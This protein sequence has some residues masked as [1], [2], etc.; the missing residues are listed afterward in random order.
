LPS[1]GLPRRQ[2]FRRPAHPFPE[3]GIAETANGGGTIFLLAGPEIA[4]GKAAKYGG[5]PGVRAFALQREE[6][7]LH[8]IFAHA[9]PSPRTI[10]KL[11]HILPE[12]V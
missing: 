4:A 7:F 8:R 3:I 2:N 6:D 1:Q 10:D 11:K 12:G 5:A 9:R